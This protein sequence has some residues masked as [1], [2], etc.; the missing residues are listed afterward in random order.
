MVLAVRDNMQI[1]FSCEMCSL[2]AQTDQE[3]LFKRVVQFNPIKNQ[4]GGGSGLGLMGTCIRYY[5]STLWCILIIHLLNAYIFSY[6][7]TVTKGI[8]ELHGGKISV[9]SEGEGHGSTFIVSLPVHQVERR[10]QTRTRHPSLTTSKTAPYSIRSSLMV[11]S[12]LLHRLWDTRRGSLGP[13]PVHPSQSD[14]S[15]KPIVIANVSPPVNRMPVLQRMDTGFA[16]SNSSSMEEKSDR[17]LLA[18]KP[19]THFSAK[20]N[21]TD[22][23]G[24]QD[25]TDIPLSPQPWRRSDA[26]YPNISGAAE[27]YAENSILRVLVVDNCTM[28]RKMLCRILRGRFDDILEADNGSTALE[29]VRLSIETCTPVDLV[30]LDYETPA[31]DGPTTVS[32]VRAIGYSG[33][34]IALT[35]KGEDNNDM[36]YGV[37]ALLAKPSETEVLYQTIAGKNI[38]TLG[39]SAAKLCTPHICTSVIC[40]LFI[41]V[42]LSSIYHIY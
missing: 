34:I 40:V 38:S 8:V 30:L 17:F 26:L 4:Q 11:W 9:R 6:F 23:G 25:L 15:Q 18:F 12:R 24:D 28:N 39:F 19:E 33:S 20:V 27:N 31:M 13:R 22:G 14:S 37:D 7:D 21:P 42:L 1:L 36:S 32:A 41:F 29:A 10:H 2:C 16:R 35:G 5:L 3:Q